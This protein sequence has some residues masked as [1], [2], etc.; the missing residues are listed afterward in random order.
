M[1]VGHETEAIETFRHALECVKDSFDDEVVEENMEVSIISSGCNHIGENHTATFSVASAP[2]TYNRCDSLETGNGVDGISKGYASIKAIP[3]KDMKAL[4]TVHSCSSNDLSR[5]NIPKEDL[6]FITIFDRALYIDE[7]S[8]GDEGVNAMNR[9][10]L[11]PEFLSSLIT[12]NMA[13]ASHTLGL[14]NGSSKCLFKALQLYEI[15]HKI[16]T[17]YIEYEQQQR[18]G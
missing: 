18:G 3:L 6:T 10:V 15:A 13:L 7:C 2:T 14:K 1:Q 8:C 17:E 16:L 11:G 9:G 12:Y 4:E 5:T